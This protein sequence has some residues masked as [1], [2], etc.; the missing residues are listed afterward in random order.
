MSKVILKPGKEKA[1]LQRHPWIFSGAIDTFPSFENGEILPIYSASG[2]FLAKAYF[3][4]ENSLAGRVLTFSDESIEEILDKRLDAAIALREKVIDKESTTAYRLINAE[5]DGLPGLIV[6]LYDGVAVIQIHTCGMQRLKDRLI[7]TLRKKLPIRGIYEK[8]QSPARHQEGLSPF[9]GAVLGECPHEILVKENGL[10]FLIPIVEGQ[11]TGF[12]LDQREMR[13]L[14]KNH[15]KGRRVLNCFSYTGGFSLFALQGGA[16]EVTSVDS[17]P[18]ACRL[19]KEQTLLNHMPLDRH[20]VI[21]EDVFDYLNQKTLPFDLV[22]LD[23]P[24]FAKKRQDIHEACRGYKEINRRALEKMPPKSLLLTSSCS[25]FIDE[26]LFQ[27]VVFQAALE[28][29]RTVQI[30]GKHILAA[31]H[32]VSLYHPEGS[33][34]KSLWLYLD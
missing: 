21:E 1:L 23:P 2:E 10:H 29:R 19:A 3:H 18:L 30:V 28:A 34:L 31:D 9:S 17:S 11:K 12:F 14:I 26:T 7:Q 16:T 25:H 24:A 33:Y 27:Q 22:I 4:R 15:A 5:G 32:P 6:D 8:S 13:Q 20:Q